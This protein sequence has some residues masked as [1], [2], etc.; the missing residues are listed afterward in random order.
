ME[1]GEAFR[2]IGEEVRQNFEGYIAPELGI[3]RAVDLTP[4]AL[5]DEGGDFIDMMK[6]LTSRDA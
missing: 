3:V 6:R 4:A 1:P 5:T 2:V